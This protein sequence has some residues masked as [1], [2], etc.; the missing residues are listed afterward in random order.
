MK[1]CADKKN[2]VT[3]FRKNGYYTISIY[4]NFLDGDNKIYFQVIAPIFFCSFFK[5][6]FVLKVMFSKKNVA[7]KFCFILSA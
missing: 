7:C 5:L 4:E 6:N 3:F 1:Q 2:Y